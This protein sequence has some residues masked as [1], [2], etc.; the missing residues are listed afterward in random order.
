MLKGKYAIITGAS[1]GIGK[2]I[3][4]VFAANG[5]CLILNSRKEG[6]LK[7]MTK[8][9]REK[10]SINVDA[11]HFDVSQ[12]DQVKD[13]FKKIFSIS[14]KIDILVNNAGILGD[15][16]LGIISPSIVQDTFGTNTFGTIYCSQYASRLMQRSGGGSI[17]NISSIMGTNG[18]IGQ[19]IYSGSKAAIVGITKSLA[20]ELAPD[21]RVNAVAPGFIDTDMARSISKRTFMERVASIRMNRVGMPE[22]VARVVLFLASDMSSYV[23]GE[24]IGVDGGM[25]I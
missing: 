12:Y 2:S 17:I 15:A 19:T 23:T 11:V 10:Y 18:N 22:E 7:D 3:A 20:K 25:L 4:E 5:A 6:T 1:R 24:V 13:A 14:R 16:L 9:L 21:I 8:G